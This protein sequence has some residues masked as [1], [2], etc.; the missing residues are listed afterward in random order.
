MKVSSKVL[1][2]TLARDLRISKR[3][4]FN[5]NDKGISDDNTNNEGGIGQ[6]KIDCA[7]EHFIEL[8]KYYE[9]VKSTRSYTAL[10][11][12][13]LLVIDNCFIFLLSIYII[14]SLLHEIHYP[15]GKSDKNHNNKEEKSKY[16]ID[17]AREN[18]N[19]T[20]SVGIISNNKE[21]FVLHHILGYLKEL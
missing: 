20:L 16:L 7:E 11:A 6:S 2:I 12:S 15:I 18:F 13:I 4:C 5:C 9:S 14:I 10:V 3:M 8:S 19:Q 1:P 17:E 21:P